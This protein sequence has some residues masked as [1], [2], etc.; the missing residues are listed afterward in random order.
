M[1]FASSESSLVRASQPSRLPSHGGLAQ[2]R[3]RQVEQR[4]MRT[5]TAPRVSGAICASL[6]PSS[7]S[8]ARSSSAPRAS[9]S[10]LSAAACS[11]AAVASSSNV[12]AAKTNWRQP[13]TRGGRVVAR[14]SAHRAAGLARCRTH[15][16]SRLAGHGTGSA[17]AAAAAAVVALVGSVPDEG[18]QRACCSRRSSSS[19]H[20]AFATGTTATCTP[21]SGD[22][23]SGK[24]DGGDGGGS[25]CAATRGTT[26]SAAPVTG[27]ARVDLHAKMRHT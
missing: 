21:E 10:Q 22:G 3:P 13:T 23:C 16:R 18:W 26:G 12:A 11:S 6:L 4:W 17:A 15:S 24:D 19:M 2:R 27:T 7:A 5:A 9:C 25:R 14:A 8:V 20:A 1:S